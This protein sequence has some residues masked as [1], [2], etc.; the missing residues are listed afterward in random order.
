MPRACLL[1]SWAESRPF[2][3]RE[4][5]QRGRQRD[6]LRARSTCRLINRFCVSENAVERFWFA[7]RN[8]RRLKS[9]CT[10]PNNVGADTQW[11]VV[12]TYILHERFELQHGSQNVKATTTIKQWSK[13]RGRCC[14]HH[15]SSPETETW[16]SHCENGVVVSYSNINTELCTSTTDKLTFASDVDV[17]H[18]AISERWIQI[19]R[20][21]Y[22]NTTPDNLPRYIY[23]LGNKMPSRPHGGR[24][25][26]N[27]GYTVKKENTRKH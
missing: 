25:S 9:L 21:Y 3:L 17:V 27:Q 20:T 7:L 6:L 22:P 4:D 10:P 16:T 1:I 24:A 15:A 26:L 12:L 5:L 11:F 13:H 2:S 14:A 19:V 18:L 23:I 8:T